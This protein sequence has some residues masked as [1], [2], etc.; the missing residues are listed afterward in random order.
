M[1]S[2]S[3]FINPLKGILGPIDALVELGAGWFQY[4]TTPKAHGTIEVEYHC[5][6]PTTLHPPTGGPPVADGGGD[7]GPDDCLIAAARE[8]S[9]S[10]R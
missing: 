9:R 2:L 4:M 10:G 7:D 5:P 6:R 8:K 3:S 1:P